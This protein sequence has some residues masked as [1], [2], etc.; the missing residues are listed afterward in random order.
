MGL[1]RV[2]VDE[3][4]GGQ[5]SAYETEKRLLEGDEATGTHVSQY[6]VGQGMNVGR[7]LHLHGPGRGRSRVS[8]GSLVAVDRA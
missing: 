3:L 8:G 5:G 7:E 1:E 6:V 2:R 4:W